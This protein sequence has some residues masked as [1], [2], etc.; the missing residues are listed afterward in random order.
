[1]ASM[2]ADVGDR[3]ER[4]PFV[5]FVIRASDGHEYPLPSRDRAHISPRSN[6]IVVFLDTGPAVLLGPIYI[7]SIVDHQT[8]GSS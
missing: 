5:P 7:N 2:I 4:V 1:M 8:D 6:R 3:L